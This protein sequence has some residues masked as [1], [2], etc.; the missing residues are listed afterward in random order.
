MKLFLNKFMTLLSIFREEIQN[1]YHL[2]TQE[3]YGVFF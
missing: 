2:Y 3:Y 1:T